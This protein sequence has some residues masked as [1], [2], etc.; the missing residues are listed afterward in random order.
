MKRK[1]KKKTVDDHFA[2]RCIQ[3]LGYVP[4]Q[5]ELVRQ[6]QN[7]MLE[8][9]D[10]QS[11]RVTRWKWTDPVH[12]VDCILP[13]DKDRKQIITVLFES[14]YNDSRLVENVEVQKV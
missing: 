7:N 5:K 2:R 10:R 3:R 14:I 11:L 1:S 8:Y 6:I 4:N 12:K 9:V 13:Y